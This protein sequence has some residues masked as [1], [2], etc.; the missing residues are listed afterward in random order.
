MQTIEERIQELNSLISNIDM[1]DP[2]QL[3]ELHS[4]AMVLSTDVLKGLTERAIEL[5]KENEGL[6]KMLK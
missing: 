2:V 4:K 1:N 6:K 5:E 3:K